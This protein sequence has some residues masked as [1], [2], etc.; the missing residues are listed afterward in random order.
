MFTGMPLV[1]SSC[2]Q[3]QACGTNRIDCIVGLVVTCY[4]SCAREHICDI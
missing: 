1:I 4:V 3:S 2:D